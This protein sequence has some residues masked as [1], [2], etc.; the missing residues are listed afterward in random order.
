MLLH[1]DMSL[2]R[3]NVQDFV[4]VIVHKE[5]SGHL[6]ATGK[7]YEEAVRDCE[8]LLQMTKVGTSPAFRLLGG[9]TS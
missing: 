4:Q 1:L 7:M 6:R 9:S 5:E 3:P 2:Q 8:T